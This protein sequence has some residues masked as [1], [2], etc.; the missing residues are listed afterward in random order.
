MAKFCISC[1]AENVDNAT[2]CI[3]CGAKFPAM[4][5]SQPSQD[6]EKFVVSV[7]ERE[8]E[9][10]AAVSTEKNLGNSGAVSTELDVV[11]KLKFEDVFLVHRENQ[12]YDGMIPLL[13][14]VMSQEISIDTI[15]TRLKED[16]KDGGKM[17]FKDKNSEKFQ[18][19][20]S[21][22]HMTDIMDSDEEALVYCD[23][24]DKGKS[25]VFLTNKRLMS[26][27]IIGGKIYSLAYRDF[28]DFY[29]HD[30]DEVKG[31]AKGIVY[32]TATTTAVISCDTKEELAWLLALISLFKMEKSR[33]NNKIFLA[34]TYDGDYDLRGV[35][36]QISWTEVY[37]GKEEMYI[38]GKKKDA[39]VK[40]VP[41]QDIS[42]VKAKLSYHWIS[43]CYIIVFFIAA[44]F[45]AG[46]VALAALFMIWLK[47]QKKIIITMR[48]GR[49]DVMYT[50]SGSEAKEFVQKVQ[51]C[52][53][54]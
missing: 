30:G 46:A 14:E 25:G 32:M 8:Q 42:S 2:F 9:S 10:F 20:M 24:D 33:E 44:I 54:G 28:K 51:S 43:L 48:D 19:A 7:E 11:A 52:M 27:V 21:I 26:R 49:T 17:A 5:Q 37:L 47:F 1:S 53:T 15:L 3:G 12:T 6:Q 23:L 36:E 39:P 16:F 50:R 4:N 45:T 13:K 29:F 40:C 22:W 38:H 35:R 31:E 41:Y 34:K 18:R